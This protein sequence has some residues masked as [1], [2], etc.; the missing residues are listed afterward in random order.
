MHKGTLWSK[1]PISQNRLKIPG[2]IKVA[3]PVGFDVQAT[4]HS[5]QALHLIADSDGWN[6]SVSPRIFLSWCLLD[7]LL[8]LTIK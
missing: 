2:A 1:R 7:L 6:S 8:L 3:D 5:R 4:N